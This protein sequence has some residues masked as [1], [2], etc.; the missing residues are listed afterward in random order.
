[1]EK[2]SQKQLLEKQLLEKV[3]QNNFWGKV[4]QKHFWEKL[5]GTTLT[6]PKSCFCQ[7]FFK[8]L[9]VYGFSRT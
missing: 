6:F 3:G 5:G 2:V 4:R 1:L 7:T 8:S 9:Y